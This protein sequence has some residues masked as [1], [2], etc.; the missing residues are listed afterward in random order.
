VE[1]AKNFGDENSRGFVNGILD[2]AARA[3]EAGK[4]RHR[5]QA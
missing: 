3:L 1:L 2:A 5:G 4:E